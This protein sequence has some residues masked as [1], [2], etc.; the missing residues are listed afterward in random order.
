MT[1]YAAKMRWWI[2]LLVASLGMCL[3]HSLSTGLGALFI[4]FIPKL[5]T[6]IVAIALF[7][8]MGGHAIYQSLKEYRTRYLRKKKGLK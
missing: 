3:M 2:V 4:L 6:T 7:W 8:L 1:I 5:W